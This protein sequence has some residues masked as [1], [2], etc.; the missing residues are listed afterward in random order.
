MAK[1]TSDPVKK[2]RVVKAPVDPPEKP[3]TRSLA[4]LGIER[5]VSAT[6]HRDVLKNAPYNPRVINEDERRRL[7]KGIE[8]V[9]VVAP[10]TWNLRTGNLV[11][12]H[13][14]VSILDTLAGTK[15]YTLTVSQIDVDEKRE[16]EI[17]LLLNNVAAQGQWDAA[18]LEDLLRTPDLDIEA[19]GF[20]AADVF[21]MFGAESLSPEALKDMSERLDKIKEAFDG[22]PEKRGNAFPD[23]FYF[24]VVFRDYEARAEFAAKLGLDDNRYQ[25]GRLLL[26]LLTEKA[27]APPAPPPDVL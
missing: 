5:F 25:D 10:V 15:D 26:A 8:K 19:T 3:P 7:K 14:R 20:N 6:V 24:V 12:G 23:D 27:P 21:R 16:K 13:Q 17:N 18:G 1:K 22:A 2:Q 11:G 9:G 4:E